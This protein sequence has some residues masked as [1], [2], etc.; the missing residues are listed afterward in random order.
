MAIRQTISGPNISKKRITGDTSYQRSAF[1]N[2]IS[3]KPDFSKKKSLKFPVPSIR[4]QPFPGPD[5]VT[6]FGTGCFPVSFW[7]WKYFPGTAY[8]GNDVQSREAWPGQEYFI[9]LFSK[10][11]ITKEG[12]PTKALKKTTRKRT[13]NY[14]LHPGPARNDGIIYGISSGPVVITTFLVMPNLYD[15]RVEVAPLFGF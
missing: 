9:S 7:V 1:P 2:S 6:S 4:E 11:G 13:T 5:S 15:E 14:Y 3:P 12:C 10:E 8:S